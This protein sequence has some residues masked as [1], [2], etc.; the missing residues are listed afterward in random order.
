METTHQIFFKNSKDMC[1]IDSNTIDLILTSPPYPMIEI[2][3][4]LFSSLNE[5]IKDF[6]QEQD[7]KTAF[8]L[9]HEELDKVWKESVRVL[10]EG[11]LVCINIGDATRTIN[12]NFQLFPN[13]IKVAH[14]FQNNGF[15]SLP[16]ILWRKPTN[17]PTKFM[18]SGMLP[19]N[20][21]VTLE[22]EYILIF[23]KGE[24]KRNYPPKSE[25]RYNSAYFWEERNK[26][27]SDIW[28]DIRGTSQSLN[29]NKILRE[30]SA[31]FPLKLPYR[32]I[33]MFSIYGDTI[34]D[35]FWGTGTT[36]LA[37]MASA[38]NSIGYEINLEFM[39]IFK[40]NVEEIKRLTNSINNS[41]ISQHIEFIKE[42]KKK[43]KKIIHNSINYKFPVITLQEKNLL[44]YSINNWI[45]DV[46]SYRIKH[47]KFDY[48]HMIN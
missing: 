20:A 1:E 12:K 34:L 5:D 37:A 42:Y 11:G 32:L 17:S 21:Y 31:A 3:D 19:C 26:W 24:N 8:R 4:P 45:I 35:P 18:G 25:G 14:F 44:L 10:K 7:G 27:F 40:K 2:W 48:N 41:R 46:N 16:C 23:R 15:L 13:H 9:M 29:S 47:K 33:N 6:L 22:H 30:K 36:S 43:N 28:N 39:E 38:R